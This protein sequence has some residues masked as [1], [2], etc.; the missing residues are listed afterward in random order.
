MFNKHPNA[1]AM[2][3]VREFFANASEGTS[4]HM[5][6]VRGKQVKYDTT[7]INQ[8]LHLPYKPNGPNKVE[9]LMNTANMEEVSRAIC[10]K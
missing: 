2:K 10:K 7:T 8:L 3:V 9:Y 6:F 1:A 4:G 5:V